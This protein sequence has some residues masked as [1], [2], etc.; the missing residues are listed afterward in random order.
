MTVEGQAWVVS[1]PP[2]VLGPVSPLTVQA[3][4]GQTVTVSG[5]S[6]AAQLSYVAT[7]PPQI[8]GPA[9]AAIETPVTW[10]YGALG[11]LAA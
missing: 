5:T 2:P 8:V 9:A 4:G 6:Q 10:N 3:L 7:Q 11:S 1:L